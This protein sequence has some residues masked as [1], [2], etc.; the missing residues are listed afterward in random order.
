MSNINGAIGEMVVSVSLSEKLSINAFN[1]KMSRANDGCLNQRYTKIPKPVRNALKP[2]IPV[3]NST[4]RKLL[5][6]ETRAALLTP[7]QYILPRD[8][9]LLNP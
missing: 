1:T 5:C 8:S 4:D 3:L 6:V 7:V 9:K 2:M